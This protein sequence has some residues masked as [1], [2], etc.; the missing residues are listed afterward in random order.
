M[1]IWE[2]VLSYISNA[3]SAK[4]QESSTILEKYR[5]ALLSLTMELVKK[6]QFQHNREQLEDLSEV[7]GPDEV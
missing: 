1:E 7:V 2:I 5:E 6:V 3:V 4:M